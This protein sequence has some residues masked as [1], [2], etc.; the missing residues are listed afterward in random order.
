MGKKKRVVAISD[1]HCGHR[2]GL[3]PPD[4]A[5]RNT[6]KWHTAQRA[7]WREYCRMVKAYSPVDVLFVLGDVID[8][9]GEKSGSTELIT[10]DRETQ[11]QMAADCINMWKAPA[12]VMVFGTAYHTGQKEDWEINVAGKVNA[13]KIGGQEWVQIDNVMFDLKHFIPGSG[14]PHGKGTQLA[15]EWLWNLVWNIRDEQPKADIFLRGH[16]HSFDGSFND[17]YL[18]MTLPALQGLGSKYGTKIPAKRVDF[19][20]VYFDVEGDKYTWDRDIV[21]V[22]AQKP[23][24]LQF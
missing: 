7:L 1:L 16:Q 23:K 12:I 14:I 24:V 6:N 3:T 22:K 13:D 9:R 8:G 20:M 5:P 21:V 18:A 15:K 11:C 2:I 17:N 10:T 19:G 4:Y